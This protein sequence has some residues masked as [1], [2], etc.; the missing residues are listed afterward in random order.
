[1]E[2]LNKQQSKKH[3]RMFLLKR[4]SFLTVIPFFG[5]I[6]EVHYCTTQKSKE[7]YMVYW[8]VVKQQVRV[9]LTH[10]FPLLAF[11]FPLNIAR[12]I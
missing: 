4:N 2:N 9:F 10:Y 11:L 8:L 1:M 6:L 3:S 7:N 12:E 5:S